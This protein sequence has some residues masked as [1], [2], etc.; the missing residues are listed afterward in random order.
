MS[1]S[2]DTLTTGASALLGQADINPKNTK[3]LKS[4]QDFESVFLN[5]MLSSMT[6]GLGNDTG[7]DGGDA[8]TQWRS[9]LNEYTARSISA[10]GGVGLSNTVMGELL[11]AQG[12]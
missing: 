9:L 12:A 1:S 11:K 3:A 8:E 4:G 2:I 7:F 5:Q 10:S 6:Q